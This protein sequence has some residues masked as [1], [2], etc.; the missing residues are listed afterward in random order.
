MSLFPKKIAGKYAVVLTANTDIP[1]SKIAVAYF[2]RE[3]QM[4]S[5]TYWKSWYSA[6]DQNTIPLQR[7]LKDHVE[8][9]APPI[10]TKHGWLLIYSYIKNYLSPPAVFG[11]EAVLLDLHDPQKI[12]ARTEKPLLVPQEKYE[13][14]QGTKYRFPDWCDIKRWHSL[15]LL[16][17]GRYHLRRRHL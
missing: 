10:K 15:H 16:W 9:G 14:W 6:L 11:V 8:T 4:W 1:P 12:I 13:I 3:E 7:S 17:S 2:D 5:P